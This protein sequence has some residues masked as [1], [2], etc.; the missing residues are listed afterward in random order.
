MTAFGPIALESLRDQMIE[1]GN[2]RRY[3][4]DV[5]QV[6]RAIFKWG[7]RKELCPIEVHQRLATIPG[8]MKGRS[9]AKE[10]EPVA[11]VSLE[12]FEA[13]LPFL[14]Q[15]VADMARFQLHTACRPGESTMLRPCDIDR[16]GDIW[17]YRPSSH[18]TEHHG[19]SREI[20][21]NRVSDLLAE[22]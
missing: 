11:P 15:V 8:L 21:S 17:I 6:I 1:R 22:L 19:R 3:I 14:P 10:T 2:S 12:D 4:N 7:V 5:T 16:S 20:M 9:K 18:K 13:T